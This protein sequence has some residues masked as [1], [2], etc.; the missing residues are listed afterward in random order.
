LKR[1][2]HLLKKLDKLYAL[3]DLKKDL[4]NICHGNN[5]VSIIINEK[6]I[7]KVLKIFEK[8]KNLKQQKNLVSLTITFTDDFITTPG[9]LFAITRKLAWHGINMIELVSANTELSIILKR[10]DVGKAYEVLQEIMK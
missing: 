10:E 4:L 3:V 8:E 6:Y 9:M 2:E 5:D 7:D 1:S